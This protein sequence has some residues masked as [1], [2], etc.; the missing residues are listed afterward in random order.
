MLSFDMYLFA[1]YLINLFDN[2]MVGWKKYIFV[3]IN[4]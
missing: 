3:L 1:S 4:F 2:Q